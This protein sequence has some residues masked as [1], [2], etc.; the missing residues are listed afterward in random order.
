MI[1]KMF[2]GILLIAGSRRKVTEDLN[3]GGMSKLDLRP[4][5]SKAETG[6][7]IAR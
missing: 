5:D 7:G 3:A 1:A 4:A 2:Y 6:T